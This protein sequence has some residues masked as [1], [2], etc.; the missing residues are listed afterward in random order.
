MGSAS[1]RLAVNS[2]DNVGGVTGRN[3]DN[4][5]LSLALAF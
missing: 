3:A 1:V 4:T 2:A 5:E